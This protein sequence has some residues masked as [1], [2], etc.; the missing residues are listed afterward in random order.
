MCTKTVFKTVTF[1]GQ[2]RYT[3][4]ADDYPVRVY[5]RLCIRVHAGPTKSLCLSD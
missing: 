1:P 2:Y 3:G 5:K 4:H